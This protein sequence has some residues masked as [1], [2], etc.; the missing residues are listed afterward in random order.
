M[1][2]KSQLNFGKLTDYFHCCDINTSYSSHKAT[3]IGLSDIASTFTTGILCA[4]ERKLGDPPGMRQLTT[5][6]KRLRRLRDQE[7]RKFPHGRSLCREA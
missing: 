6:A 3:E 7:I 5:N 4:R 1:K 2:R